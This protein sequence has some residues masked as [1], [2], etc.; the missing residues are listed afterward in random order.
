MT[1]HFMPAIWM[2]DWGLEITEPIRITQS[3]SAE[4]LC[5][6]PRKLYVKE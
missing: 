2:E 3:G 1:F 5:D 4:C 6:R